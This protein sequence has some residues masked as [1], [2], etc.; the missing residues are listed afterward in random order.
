MPNLCLNCSREHTSSFLKILSICFS[1][2]RALRRRQVAIS[3]V[4][5]RSAS[6]EHSSASREVKAQ[7]FS[8]ISRAWR[9][10]PDGR[11]FSTRHSVQVARISSQIVRHDPA[12]RRQPCTLGRGTFPEP[13]IFYP[14]L[15]FGL[16]LAPAIT[17]TPASVVVKCEERISIKNT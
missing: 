15:L 14:C 9:V 3:A 13:F 10:G 7:N 5:S 8:P 12:V 17:L 4:L 16:A 6:R 1:T 11:L 2:V